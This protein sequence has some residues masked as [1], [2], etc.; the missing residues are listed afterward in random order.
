MREEYES[1][2]R[3]GVTVQLDCPDLAM[4]RHSS[5][6]SLDLPA[7]RKRMALNIEALNHAVRNIPAEQA[8]DAL[9]LGQLSGPASL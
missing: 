2:A 5:Y 1:I 8:P 7:F 3:A 4:G 6:A 9:V